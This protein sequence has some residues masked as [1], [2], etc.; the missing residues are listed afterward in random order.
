MNQSGGNGGSNR[1]NY[2]YNEPFKQNSF[3]QS[4]QLMNIDDLIHRGDPV[5][6][7]FNQLQREIDNPQQLKPSLKDQ[8]EL[9]KILEQPQLNSL[10][11]KD[12][13]LI[14]KYRYFIQAD[15][16]YLVK[17]LFSVN[18]AN[19]EEV[20]ESIE[21]MY[22]WQ[23]IE[24]YDALHLLSYYY[25]NNDQFESII[26]I[27]NKQQKFEITQRI[28]NYAVKIIKS[29]QEQK[30]S[31]ILLQ[32]VQALRYEKIDYESI[33]EIENESTEVTKLSHFL[34]KRC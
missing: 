6:N 28:R 32:L 8:E 13:N 2:Y 22:N 11:K 4:I 34:I 17:F 23:E 15:K 7:L 10:Q 27:K 9:L 31:L 5:Q 21:M 30:L 1:I 20:N 3:C 33:K 18:W 26:N 24:F 25:S 16:E 14:W 29:L 19:V 12:K